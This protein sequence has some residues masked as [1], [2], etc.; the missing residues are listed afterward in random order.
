MREHL[1]PWLWQES[2]GLAHE[3]VPE[4]AT[5]AEVVLSTGHYLAVGRTAHAAL[6]AA[7]TD[8]VS[9]FV[10]VQHG[11]LTP[12]APPLAA[13]TTLLAWSEADAEFWRSGRD[14]VETAVVGS[15]LLWDAAEPRPRRARPRS[16]PGVPRP[17]ARGGAAARGADRGGRGVLPGGG[18][19]LPTPP[20]RAR[21][22][23]LET[24]RRWEG[25]GITIDRSGVPLRELGAP[26]VSVF[27]TGVLEA[28]AAGLPAWVHCPDPPAWLRGFWDRY[29]LAR[30][31]RRPRRIPRTAPTGAVPRGRPQSAG[32]DGAVRILCVIPARGGSKGVPGKNLR[33]VRGKPLLVWTVEQALAARPAM[34]VVV[35]TDDARSPGRPGR[36]RAG[37]VPRPADLALDTTP[38][39]PVVRHAI[40]AARRADAAPTP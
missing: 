28:A 33:D 3:V 40:D 32:D 31:G 26:V 23:S 2:G 20:V 19:R 16:P 12:H 15:Q 21:P 1:P 38:T 29:D 13:G 30:L 17:A 24:H 22:R 34:D 27:S 39:E 5:G 4:L 8:L 11:L 25:A 36:R 14:D 10:T 37:A 9:R 35:S 7:D 6:A 18:R